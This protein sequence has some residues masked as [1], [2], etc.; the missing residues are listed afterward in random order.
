MSTSSSPSLSSES[1]SLPEELS[2][3]VTFTPGSGSEESSESS[4]SLDSFRETAFLATGFD[5]GN[6][7][8]SE[9]SPEDSSSLDSSLELGFDFAPAF[10]KEAFATA[11]LVRVG[12]VRVD[13]LAAGF[14]TG[15]ADT[16]LAEA[17]S[18]DSS[19]D[20]SSLDSSL[21]LDS[22][23]GAAA[24]FGGGAFGGGAFPEVGLDFVALN[25]AL[26]STALVG[27]DLVTGFDGLPESELSELSSLWLLTTGFLETLVGVAFDEAVFGCE[28]LGANFGESSSE[29]LSLDSED[30]PLLAE[31]FFEVTFLLVA[32]TGN[33]SSDS[34][35]LDSEGEAAFGGRIL[36]CC[37]TVKQ[38]QFIDTTLHALSH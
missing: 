20:S 25:P 2:F 13:V 16:G 17:S 6:G 4:D 22:A 33:S 37:R 34:L 3:L 36:D 38:C 11:G 10:T 23:A 14:A 30:D 8:S 9:S 15:F 24:A 5:V 21:E 31:D 27:A 29:S 32:L 7:A 1:E 26:A 35:S 19:S 18:E 28:A 12:F